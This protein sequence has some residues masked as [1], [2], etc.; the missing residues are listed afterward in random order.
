MALID[1]LW[2]TAPPESASTAEVRGAQMV[3]ANML[4]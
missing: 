3:L 1:D 2:R 4:W